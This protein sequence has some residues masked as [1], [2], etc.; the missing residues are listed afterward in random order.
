MHN[1]IQICS[2]SFILK[3]VSIATEKCR[4]LSW[5]SR[6]LTNKTLKCWPERPWTCSLRWRGISWGWSRTCETPRETRTTCPACTCSARRCSWAACL[7][8]TPVYRLNNQH[9]TTT[10]TIWEKIILSRFQNKCRPTVLNL[11][12]TFNLIS[13]IMG[14]DYESLTNTYIPQGYP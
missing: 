10:H 14:R 13:S 8:P 9:R 1:T 6:D 5:H 11:L 7:V 4:L 3:I 12:W 2:N